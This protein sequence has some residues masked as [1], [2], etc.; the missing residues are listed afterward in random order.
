MTDIRFLV[1]TALEST[2]NCDRP[3]SFLGEWCRR[4]SRSEIWKRLDIELQDYH[5]DD[6]EKYFHDYQYL[7]ILYERK[8]RQLSCVLGKM[9]NTTQSLRYWRII[10]GPWL[11]FFIDALFDRFESVRTVHDAGKTDDTWLLQYDP[12][13]WSPLDFREFYAQFTDDPWN[14][15]IFGECIR[16][17]GLPYTMRDERLGRV[18]AN[19]LPH[20]R[21][22]GFIN[23]IC[24]FYDKLLPLRFTRFALVSAYMPFARLARFQF[25]LR[26]LPILRSPSLNINGKPA[27]LSQRKL[28]C[29]EEGDT[30]YERLLNRLIPDLIPK[31]YVENFDDLRKDALAKFPRNPK[32]LFT[33]NA[34]QAD[35]GF[36]A[37]AAHYVMGGVPLVIGQ[38]GGNMGIARFNQTE[39]H[40][41]RIANVFASWGWTK[42]A[43]ASVCSMPS[44]KLGG[45]A[46]SSGKSGDILVT[47]ASLPRYFY[48]SFSF[49]VSGQFLNYIQE[50]VR[51]VEA[52]DS[53]LRD[54]IKIRLNSDSFGWEIEDRLKFA[55]LGEAIDTSQD[56]FRKRLD[57]CRV[58]VATYNATV[59]LETLA[60]N[61]PTLVFFDPGRFEFRTEA[62]AAMNELSNAGILHA[63]P[64]SAA[65]LLNAIGRDVGDWWNGA[66]LQ[67]ARR[68][69]C[70]RYARVSDD[71]IDVWRSFFVALPTAKARSGVSEQ[72]MNEKERL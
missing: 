36:K 50:Q 6:R 53:D 32:V 58:S 27:D 44:L 2:W 18:S 46:P 45:V 38:H 25:G 22:K 33:A 72:I 29:D 61:F 21:L 12:S 62:E 4:F 42:A 59:F 3:L 7:E 39:N 49:P 34:Y 1:T 70:D 55:G 28:L 47:I 71:W 5:W 30:T 35:D 11:R 56:R 31:V 17:I 48:C 54:S 43:E 40:Q 23:L 24:S 19:P 10:I 57:G 67:V 63:T 51:F 41:V 37:W 14:H 20:R 68:E 52:L 64:E 66:E 13:E 60:W 15:L 69:F 8:L 9:H 26:Q 65:R 16:S